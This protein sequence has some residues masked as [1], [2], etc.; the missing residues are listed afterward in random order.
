MPLQPVAAHRE[1][2]HRASAE[3]RQLAA[4]HAETRQLETGRAELEKR[5]REF[6]SAKSKRAPTLIRGAS[7]DASDGPR[8]TLGSQVLVR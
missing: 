8:S 6:N 2:S 7:K 1:Q 3:Y 5:T 4:D